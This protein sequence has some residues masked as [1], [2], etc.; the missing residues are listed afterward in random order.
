MSL[1]LLLPKRNFEQ[2]RKGKNRGH[3]EGE[4]K[5]MRVSD[6]LGVS[7]NDEKPM[8][9]VFLVNLIKQAAIIC[10]VTEFNSLFP[11]GRWSPTVLLPNNNVIHLLLETLQHL[12]HAVS[13]IRFCCQ[14]IK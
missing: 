7:I 2:I 11:K 10:I 3:R 13:V 9:V 5:T 8:D 4:G 6:R 1:L 14:T 12:F